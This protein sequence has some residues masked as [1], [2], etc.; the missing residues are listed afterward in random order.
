MKVS[1]A[2]RGGDGA[3]RSGLASGRKAQQFTAPR[4]RGQYSPRRGSWSF[5]ATLGWEGCS[6]W[7]C[8]KLWNASENQSP[9]RRTPWLGHRFPDP[10]LRKTGSPPMGRAG[11][12]ALRCSFLQRILSSAHCHSVQMTLP[13]G[14]CWRS[15]SDRVQDG[16]W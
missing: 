1:R 12:V 3:E 9:L 2:G 15:W 10:C 7:N 14:H 4:P 8:W 13:T 16:I 11:A 6:G 5:E